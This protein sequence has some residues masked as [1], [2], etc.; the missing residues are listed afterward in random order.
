ME[1]LQAGAE[2]LGQGELTHRIHLPQQDEIGQLAATLNQMA[3]ELQRLYDQEATRSRELERRAIQLATAADVGRAAAS[4]LDPATLAREVVD[5]VRTRFGLYYVGLFL[6]DERREYAVLEAGTGEPGR[7]M[8]ERGHRLEVGGASMVGAACAQRRARIA[9]DVGV[10]SV[11]FDNPLLPDTR[12][13]GPC[14]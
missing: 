6:L 9:L 8:Q 7:I 5:L 13:E 2:R 11:R 1:T 4:I 12:S 14:R 3:G 10:E